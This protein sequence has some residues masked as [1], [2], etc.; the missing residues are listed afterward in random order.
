M[1][2]EENNWLKETARDT[3]AIGGLVFYI[4]F[5]ARATIA[6]Y[7]DYAIQLITALIIFQVLALI[8]KDT[9]QH[10]ARGFIAALFTIIFY[11]VRSFTIF[12]VAVYIA[13]LG[14]AIYLQKTK[15]QIIKGLIL[16]II[17]FTA[18]YYIA[19]YIS[20]LFS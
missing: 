9:E 16:G 8:I 13:I 11:N 10:I 18:A 4:L 20:F 7:Y 12:A 1:Q 5:I 3:L 6:P 15:S 14:S 17:S 2:K 19:P